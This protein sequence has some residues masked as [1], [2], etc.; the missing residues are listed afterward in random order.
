MR[1]LAEAGF[2]VAFTYRSSKKDAEA[3][4]AGIGRKRG[5]R[6]AI[7]IYADLEQVTGAQKVAR[8]FGR[9]FHGFVS[10]QFNEL[11]FDH[12]YCVPGIPCN[13][14]SNRNVITF[15]LDWTPRP[16]RID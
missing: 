13:R 10:F 8:A 16:I 7:A 5:P 11:S 1:N 3:L 4:A 2:D 9:E 6:R 12:S 15:G 14:I